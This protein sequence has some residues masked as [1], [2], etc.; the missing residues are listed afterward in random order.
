MSQDVKR[1]PAFRGG[2][3]LATQAAPAS[4][5]AGLVAVYVDTVDGMAKQ[6]DSAGVITPLAAAPGAAAITQV[7]VNVGATAV[8]RGKFT[9]TDAAILAG[10]QIIVAQSADVPTG[11]GTRADE[12]EMDHIDCR[13]TVTGAGAADVYWSS[14]TLVRGNFRF[15]WIAG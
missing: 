10:S 15:N 12:N 3:L 14:R 4:P 2:V 5:S 8:R 1:I 11:K 13:A 7:E 9:I 6:K